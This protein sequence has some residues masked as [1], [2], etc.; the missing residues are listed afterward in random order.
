MESNYNKENRHFAQEH[1]KF[2]TKGEAMLWKYALSRKQTG[3]QFNRQFPLDKFIVDFICRQLNLVIEID[4]NSH[5]RTEQ[6]GYDSYRQDRIESFGYT[7][8]R[9]SESEV[10]FRLDDVIKEIYFVI[11]SLK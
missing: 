7:V 10:L 11:E 4:G 9:F 1:R 6:A 3:Y 2:G 8:L 5:N